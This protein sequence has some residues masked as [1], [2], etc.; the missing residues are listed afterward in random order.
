MSTIA[1]LAATSGQDT[2]SIRSTATST[3]VLPKEGKKDYAI[4]KAWRPVALPCVIGKILERLVADELKE[5]AIKHSLIPRRQY[6][7]AGRSTAK[8]LEFITNLVIN[9]WCADTKHNKKYW[10]TSLLGLDISG[11]YDHVKRMEL[12][13]VLV[14]KRVPRWL[15]HFV[16]SFLCD[17]ATSIVLP[18]YTSAKFWVDV[19]IPQGSPLSPILFALFAAPILEI[20]EE[21]HPGHIVFGLSYVDDTYIIVSSTSWD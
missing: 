11:A 16:W 5:V 1:S 15:I 18:G 3:V 19:G 13:K 9:G 2:F 12:I 7:F 4:V 17:R 8:A 14:A 20:F 10:K 21:A 6:G